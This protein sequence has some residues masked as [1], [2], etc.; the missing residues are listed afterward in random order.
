M[1]ERYFAEVNTNLEIDCIDL[2]AGKVDLINR[3]RSRSPRVTLRCGDATHIVEPAVYDGVLVCDALH[4]FDPASHASVIA[5]IEHSLRPGGVC[6]VKDLDATPRWKH[7]WNRVHDRIVAGPAPIH[8]R[9]L[10][11]VVSLFT[12]TGFDVER[13]ERI[14]HRLTPYS[15]Y[16]MRCRKPATSRGAATQPSD[17]VE[18]TSGT[19]P[20]SVASSISA[21]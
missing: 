16:L 3:T 11:E 20:D 13:A 10:D 6:I 17:A 9:P 21:Q 15:H 8:C 12:A 1:L 18:T 2:D 14:D 4:H 5:G 7:T 19:G